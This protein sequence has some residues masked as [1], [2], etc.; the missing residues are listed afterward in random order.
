LHASK[1]LV[2]L[3]VLSSK[4]KELKFWTMASTRKEGGGGGFPETTGV[5]PVAFEFPV[6]KNILY[7]FRSA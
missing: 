7:F 5:T 2:N 3:A 6:R 1:N 4:N